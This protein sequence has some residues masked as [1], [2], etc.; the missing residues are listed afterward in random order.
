M[1]L[2]SPPD[3]GSEQP[4]YSLRD[5]IPEAVFVKG[6]NRRNSQVQIRARSGRAFIA[7]NC[8]HEMRSPL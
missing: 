2:I 1:L 5:I 4:G 6:N 7:L 3:A 8:C